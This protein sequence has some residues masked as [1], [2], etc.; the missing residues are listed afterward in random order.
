MTG[1][2][3]TE[4]VPLALTAEQV[5]EMTGIAVQTLANWRVIGKGPRFFKISRLVRYSPQSVSEWVADQSGE[6]RD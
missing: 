6:P 5:S 2:V 3:V 4:T 1:T